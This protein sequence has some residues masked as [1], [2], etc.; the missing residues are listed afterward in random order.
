[1]EVDP[2]DPADMSRCN[3][4]GE[5]RQQV[6]SGMTV[7]EVE[8]LLGEATQVESDRL[9]YLIGACRDYGVDLYEL[10]VHLDGGRVQRTEVVQG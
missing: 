9:V 5:A 2:T 6:A 1:M 8:S 7:D 4:V 3:M 10:W